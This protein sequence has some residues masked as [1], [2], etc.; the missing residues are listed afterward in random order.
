MVYLSMGGMV[1]EKIRGGGDSMMKMVVSLLVL[2][3]I[4]ICPAPT[5]AEDTRGSLWIHNAKTPNGRSYLNGFVRGYVEGNRWG[6]NMMEGILPYARFDPASR[7]DKKQIE[8]NLLM[9]TL[10]Y[11][12]ALEQENL[13][14]TI[15]QVTQWYRDVQNRR[16]SWSKL[17]DLAIGKVN[18]VHM[19]YIQHQL[20]WLQDVSIH[21][22]I[23]WFHTIDP[24]TGEGRVIYYDEN[25]RIAK[26]EWVR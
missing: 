2:F 5:R 24:A 14:K 19:N 26:T 16:I 10:Y 21:R 7:I 12:R 8:S 15:D 17:V 13:E 1:R 11:A 4:S 25:G 20:R 6:L 18:G 3:G 22:R 9:E 23:D